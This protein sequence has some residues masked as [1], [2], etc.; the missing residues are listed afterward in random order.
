MHHHVVHVAEPLL[1]AVAVHVLYPYEAALGWLLAA[2]CLDS[3]HAQLLLTA[4]CVLQFQ[5]LYVAVSFPLCRLQPSPGAHNWV[6]APRVAAPA[7]ALHSA[8]AG[9]RCVRQSLCPSSPPPH[10]PRTLVAAQEAAGG[11]ASQQGK[12][13]SG[14]ECSSGCMPCING[15][16]SISACCCPAGAS[17][18]VAV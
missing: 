8:A 14:G 16:S 15:S 5:Q 12:P 2:N 17:A 10:A 9:L 13:D 6:A 4:W 18:R 11:A 7:S 3:Q 1:L